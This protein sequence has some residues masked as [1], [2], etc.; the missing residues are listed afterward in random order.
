MYAP[1]Y[2]TCDPPAIHTV[3]TSDGFDLKFRCGQHLCASAS[4]LRA[5]ANVDSGAPVRKGRDARRQKHR[6]EI[7]QRPTVLSERLCALEG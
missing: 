6:T 1:G 7:V 4:L 5:P 2:S 3:A